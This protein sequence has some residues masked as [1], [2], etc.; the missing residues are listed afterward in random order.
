MFNRR[1]KFGIKCTSMLHFCT[2]K[3]TE[4]AVKE[5]R[6]GGKVCEEDAQCSRGWCCAGSLWIRGLQLCTP[7]GQHGDECRPYFPKMLCLRKWHYNP[8]CPCLPKHTCMRWKEGTYR[9]TEDAK[10]MKSSFRR[11]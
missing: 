9:C 4:C 11:M 7:F 10:R 2:C 1:L 5:K 6:H 8:V 3:E